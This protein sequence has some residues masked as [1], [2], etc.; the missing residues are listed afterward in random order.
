MRSNNLHVVDIAHMV[1]Q[2]TDLDAHGREGAVLIVRGDGVHVWDSE[3]RSYIE[4]MAGLWCASLG[5]SE[6]RLADAAYK[7]LLQLPYYHTFFQKGHEPSVRLAEKLVEMAPGD[8]SHVMFQCSGSEANDAAIKVIWYYNNLRGKPAKKKLIGRIRGYHGNTVAT[9]SLSGQ[10]HMQADFDLPYGDRFLH[11]SNP[12]YYRAHVEGESE[13]DFSARMATELEALI[14]REGADTIAAFF[15]EPVQGGGGAITPPEGYFD[16]I[17]PILKRHDILFVA[18]EV[19]CGFGRTGNLWGCDTYGIT[20]DILTSAKQLTAAYQP[21]SATLISRPIQEALVAGSKKHGSFGHGFTYGGHP[22][23][24]AVALETLAI[25]EE[26]DMVGHV[27]A[28]APH[29]L[30]GLGAFRDHPL[31]GD[32]RGVGLIAGVELMADKASRTPFDP[33]LKVGVRVQQKCHEAGLIVRAIGDRIAFTPPLIITEPEVAELCRRFGQGLD[34]AWVEL[35][36][37]G[38]AAA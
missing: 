27:R 33:A 1:H 4:A 13:R 5:F 26:R 32:V 14:E 7:Q 18:D 17:Q 8:L 16:L 36:G 25:Y 30:D 6:K 29:F 37:E 20:P 19:I 23:A 38:R 3:G 12:N 24:C 35:C 2:Q 22:V 31:V 11:V 15:A 10:P 34:S 9:A 21:L 28:I